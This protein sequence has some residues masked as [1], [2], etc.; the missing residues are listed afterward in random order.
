MFTYSK[1]VR[2]DK[3][4]LDIDDNWNLSP[5]MARFLSINHELIKERLPILEQAILDYREYHWKEC[6]FKADVLSYAFLIKVYDQPQ[7]HKS[8]VQYL[9]E[10]KDI[11]VRQLA[12]GSEAVFVSAFERYKTVISSDAAAW[13]YIFWVSRSILYDLGGSVTVTGRMTSGVVIT[14]P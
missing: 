4:V 1:D 6:K 7:E 9:S 8:L 2:A 13:W 12:V 5:S 14:T 10:E 11:R 3:D